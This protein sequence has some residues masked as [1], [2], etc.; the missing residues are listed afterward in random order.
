MELHAKWE[1]DVLGRKHDVLYQNG[2]HKH[3]FFKKLKFTIG[4]MKIN[5]I[6]Y[7]MV[8]IQIMYFFQSHELIKTI[9]CDMW[10]PK[11]KKKY[12]YCALD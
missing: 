1:I 2:C 6:E 7:F 3:Y 10:K 4:H 12:F 11:F 9:I 5:W 8:W